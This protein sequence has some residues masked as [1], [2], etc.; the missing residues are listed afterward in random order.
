ME[1]GLTGYSVI[2]LGEDG[3]I[4]VECYRSPFFNA[5]QA[6][7]LVLVTISCSYWLGSY[8]PLHTGTQYTPVSDYIVVKQQ[9]S[10]CPSS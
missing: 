2:Q 4:N 7:L 5:N 6:V 1:K 9:L 3:N 8:Y 10:L